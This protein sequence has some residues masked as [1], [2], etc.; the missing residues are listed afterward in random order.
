MDDEVIGF[1]IQV[2]KIGRK[3]FGRRPE[4]S[5]QRFLTLEAGWIIDWVDWVGPRAIPGKAGGTVVLLLLGW[6]DP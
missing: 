5:P 3:C 4:I 2:C 1:G 6:L